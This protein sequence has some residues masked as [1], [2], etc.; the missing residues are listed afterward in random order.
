MKL[1]TKTSLNFLSISIFVF[2]VGIVGFYYLLKNQV[3]QNLNQEL[4]AKVE[5]MI[6][7][8]RVAHTSENIEVKQNEIVVFKQIQHTDKVQ[9]GFGDTIVFNQ[10]KKAYEYYRY[11]GIVLNLNDNFY[12]I[13]ILKPLREFDNLIVRITL[14]NTVLI[15][16]I[17]FV[18]LIMNWT[19]SIRA[20]KVFYSTVDR[21]QN[22]NVRS[23]EKLKLEDSEIKEFDDLNKVLN[24]MTDRIEKDYLNIKEYTE[25]AAHEFQTPLA[26]IN[27]KMENLLQDDSL[28]EKQ[29]NAIAE[30]Y[31]ASN[32]LSRINK[33]LLLLTR[34]ENLQYPEK[35]EVKLHEIIEY[36]LNAVEDLINA[37]QLELVRDVKSV[38]IL[39]NPYLADV[40]FLNLLKNAILHNI[41][42]GL[43]QID[44]N[45]EGFSISNSGNQQAIDKKRL[46]KRFNK[47]SK[48]PDSTGLGLAIAHKICEVNDFSISYSFERKLH[49]F[50]VSFKSDQ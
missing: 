2:L 39:M 11:Y 46:F 43:I 7:Q 37:K 42:G 48:S 29:L 21:I 24:S 36:Q 38:Q 27:S 8:I 4:E 17:I 14:A 15:L 47:S 26:I 31:E 40:L 20:W 23:G 19:S 34:I 22:Y 18:L 50:K 49:Q 41:E 44:L 12:F 13:Q 28:L 5:Q 25:N 45:S 1:I 16:L 10:Q 6:S 3:N 32:R 33:T 35:E 9:R 30:A